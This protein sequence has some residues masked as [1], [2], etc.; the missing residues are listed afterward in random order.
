MYCQILCNGTYTQNARLSCC[1]YLFVVHCFNYTFVFYQNT[2]MRFSFCLVCFIFS[3]HNKSLQNRISTFVLLIL[4]CI[5]NFYQ[6]TNLNLNFCSSNC[7]FFAL[8]LTSR[9]LA[10]SLLVN[11]CVLFAFLFD[12]YKQ[13]LSCC[14]PAFSGYVSLVVFILHYQRLLENKNESIFF[15]QS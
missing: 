6:I 1:F 11:S 4:L 14:L 7:V 5:T 2:R 9:K 12:Y 10:A 3:L 8:S 15:Y 13:H